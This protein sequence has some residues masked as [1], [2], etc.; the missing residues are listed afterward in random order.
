MNIM[1]LGFF[2]CFYVWEVYIIE[3]CE[4]CYVVMFVEWIFWNDDIIVL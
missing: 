4:G 3:L 1:K 2:I